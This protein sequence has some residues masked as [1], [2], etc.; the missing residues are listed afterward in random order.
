MKIETKYYMC[1]TC[2]EIVVQGYTDSIDSPEEHQDQCNHLDKHVLAVDNYW[3]EITTPVHDDFTTRCEG[4]G[5][6][7]VSHICRSLNNDYRIKNA[8]L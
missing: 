2:A 5:S 1:Q 4:C 7:G 3:I 6:I 8:I